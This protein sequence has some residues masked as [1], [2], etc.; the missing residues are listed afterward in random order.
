MGFA[1][2]PQ[3]EHDVGG[4]SDKQ[5]VMEDAHFEELWLFN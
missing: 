4:L 3:H 2:H 1:K 5:I